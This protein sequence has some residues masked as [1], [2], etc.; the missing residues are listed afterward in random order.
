MALY[1]HAPLLGHTIPV[2]VTFFPI[3]DSIPKEAEVAEAVKCL[4]LN[5]S[6]GPSGIQAE[7][8]GQWL[9]ETKREKEPDFTKWEKVVVLVQAEF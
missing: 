6:R 4:R 9:Q 7:H 1:H 2:E 5:H 3:E 8:L